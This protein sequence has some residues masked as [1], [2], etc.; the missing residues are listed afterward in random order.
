MTTGA[1]A[2]RGLLKY[3]DRA[4]QPVLDQLKNPNELVRSVALGM[5]VA[6]LE[7]RNDP[8]SYARI[9]GLIRSSLTDSDSVVRS[10]AVERLGALTTGRTSCRRWKRSRRPILKTTRDEPAMVSMGTNFTR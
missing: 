1:M 6:L 2:T 3:G 7:K 5:S 9:R 10:S 8:I 4:L